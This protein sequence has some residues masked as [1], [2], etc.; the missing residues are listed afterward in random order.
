MLLQFKKY[1]PFFIIIV[2]SFIPLLSL[3][4]SGLP[5]TH[6]G[7]DHVARIANFYQNLVEGNIIPRWAGNLNWG[8]GHPVIMFLYPLPSYIASLFHFMGFSFVT[9]TKMVFG[10][11]FIASGLSMYLFVK[12]ILDS[13]SG[14]IASLFYLFAPYR[15]VDLYVRGAIGEHVAFIFPPLICYFLLKLSK[16]YSYWHVIGSAFSL[17]G[18]ILSHNAITIMFLPVIILYAVYLIYQKDDKKQ[19]AILYTLITIFGFALSAF[20]WI[21]AF[22]EGKYTLR[23]IVTKNS[24]S[25]FSQF[26]D[27]MYGSWNYGGT[28]QFTKQVG[29]TQWFAVITI[30]PVIMLLK[31]KKNKFWIINSGLFVIFF[32]TLF[33]M[34]PI[35]QFVWEKITLLQKFQFP[36][37][38]LSVTVFITAIFGGFFMFVVP[39]KYKAIGVVIFLCA[40]LF[41]NKDF[42]HANGYLQKQESFYASV[43]AGTTDTG[44]SA[45]IWS[46]R[47][48][49][50]NPKSP[51]ELISGDAL[52]K[53]K[54]RIITKHE[55]EIFAKEKSRI[56]ENTLYF[57]GWRVMIDGI[58]TPIE[59]Q[60]P[61]NRG[62]MTFFVPKGKHIILAEFSE[63][64]L[65]IFA[66]IISVCGLVILLFWGILQKAHVWQHFRLF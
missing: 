39:K 40:I 8:Y 21:P 59:F 5:I 38:F 42:W 17:A 48:M 65:R 54:K 26:K 36:W 9:S 60:D 16:K 19:I 52:L 44:E 49:E 33:I 45:P 63:T 31:K 34:M 37:R 7:Q 55:Y 62:L 35:S 29:I 25:N 11:A 10:L 23:D 41:L 20:F 22:F 30:L 43:Y 2:I 32:M 66:D 4:H 50:H 15:F 56:R 46:V 24:I 14:F 53:E 47:F 58:D 27:F 13:K 61:A 51:I 6:D 28:A 1:F 3:F 57:P 64:R 12:E 18:I